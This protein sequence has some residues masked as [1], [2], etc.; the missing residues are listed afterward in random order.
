MTSTH[1][2][3]SIERLSEESIR[4]VRKLAL[5]LVLQESVKI[6]DRLPILRMKAKSLGISLRDP[7]L[8][9]Y[10]KE[11]RSN[12][13]GIP[14]LI[15]ADDVLDLSEP[16][17]ICEHL[18]MARCL[19]LVIALPKIGKTSFVI[20]LLGSLSRQEETFLGFRLIGP[21][22]PILIIGTDQ[23][24]RDW[25]RILQSCD[26][27]RL[28]EDGHA[29]LC[30]PP[31]IG[32]AHSGCPWHL[33]DEGIQKIAKKA[34]ENP[35]LLI[36]VDSLHACS[37]PLGIAENTVEMADPVIGLMEA[38]GPYKATVVVI[39]HANK[40]RSPESA[41][42]GSRGSTALPA[43]ASQIIS[44]NRIQGDSPSPQGARIIL[45]TEGRA[46][47]PV[48]RLLTRDRDGTWLDQ[49]DGQ[50]AQEAER[51]ALAEEKLNQR[52]QELLQT[53]RSLY[54]DCAEPLT[55]STLQETLQFEG[56]DPERKIRSI[57]K[58]LK[59]LGLIDVEAVTTPTGQ[60]NRYQ[61]VGLPGTT[62]PPFTES[63]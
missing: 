42:M 6:S 34:E 13:A 20:A 26:L 61:P 45:H 10:L 59:D 2:S 3:L 5:E 44:L 19:N 31:I 16:E 46:G 9:S 32:L 28:D 63:T 23:P 37:R 22:P 58:R 57:L 12:V 47:A 1:P 38:V 55:V 62:D 41:S 56:Q 7:E 29:R 15:T 4:A 11:A 39:H 50:Q 35:G 40:A 52:Q 60:E 53:L 51:L 21:C 33:D 43:A 36:L 14:E 17:W 24:E 8:L 54:A 25:A 49:G 27:V 48:E 18:L 30:D